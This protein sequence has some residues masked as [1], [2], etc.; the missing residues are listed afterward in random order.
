MKMNHVHAIIPTLNR[1][2]L[3]VNCVKSLFTGTYH[4]LSLTIVVDSNKEMFDRV[5]RYFIGAQEKVTVLFNEKRIG[6]GKSMNNVIRDTDHDFYLYAS[7]DLTFHKMTIL[8]G[9]ACMAAHFPDGDGVIGFNQTNMRHFCPAAFGI[10]GR[11][12]L[13]RFPNRALFNPAYK[14]FCVDSELWHYAKQKGKFYF[15]RNAGVDHA[16]PNDAC[17]RLAQTTLQRDRAIWRP[18]K[19]SGRF[20]PEY[21]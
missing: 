7:D 13:K 20:Y 17:H 16:R 6:W 12:W 10:V 21:P 9:M 19:A 4:N 2:Q 1:F 5:H 3:L 11:Q 18:R 14:H 15:C 8:N